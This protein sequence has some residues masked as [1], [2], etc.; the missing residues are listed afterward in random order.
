MA[1]KN[2]LIDYEIFRDKVL[3]TLVNN[4]KVL[5]T[6]LKEKITERKKIIEKYFNSNNYNPTFAMHCHYPKLDPSDLMK[7]KDIY[8]KE[9]RQLHYRMYNNF[10]YKRMGQNGRILTFR[11]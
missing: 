9:R 7:R 2:P 1:Q 3:S 6:P 11:S 10:S 5:D 8:D 4:K